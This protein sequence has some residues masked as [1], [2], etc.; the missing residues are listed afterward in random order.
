MSYHGK[1]VDQAVWVLET[2]GTKEMREYYKGN[3]SYEQWLD[4]CQAIVDSERLSY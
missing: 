3:A 2:F 1:S 4:Q